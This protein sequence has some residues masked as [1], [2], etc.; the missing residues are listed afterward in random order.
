MDPDVR[1]D[2]EGSRFVVDLDDEAEAY[3]SYEEVD[4][5]TLDYTHTFVP[6]RHRGQGIAEELVLDALEYA[7]EAG[8]MIIPSCPYVRHIVEDEYPEYGSLVVRNGNGSSP[9]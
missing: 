1:H 6:E 5:R 9:E 8:R 4:D 7:R 2:E 3:L